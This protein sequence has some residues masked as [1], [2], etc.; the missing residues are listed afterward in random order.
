MTKDQEIHYRNE[1]AEYYIARKQGEKLRILTVKALII[2]GLIVALIIA[3]RW[4]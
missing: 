1:V 2:T 3:L 4:L